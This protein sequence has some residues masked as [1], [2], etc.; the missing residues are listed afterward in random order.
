MIRTR[1]ARLSLLLAVL[2]GVSAWFPFPVPE[3]WSGALLED[4]RLGEEP[5]EVRTE[6]LTLRWGTGSL[7]V[8]GLTARTPQRLLL[9][10]ERA[11]LRLDLRP[12]SPHFLRPRA[13]D[14]AGIEL[15]LLPDDLARLRPA[16]SDATFE[17]PPVELR[18]RDVAARMPFPDGR[19]LE[20]ALPAAEGLLSPSGSRIRGRAVTAYGLSAEFW[21]RAGEGFRDWVVDLRGSAEALE[22]RGHLPWPARAG[23]CE[24]ALRVDADDVL[25]RLDFRELTLQVPE[26]AVELRAPRLLLEGSLRRGMRA[27]V[28]F[29]AGPVTLSGEAWLRQPGDAPLEL[30]LEAASPQPVVIGPELIAYLRTV[31]A[32]TA[33]AF[34]ALELRGAVPLRVAL[35]W[36]AGEAPRAAAHSAF[37]DF[38]CTYR[39]FLEDDGDRPSFPY[40]ATGMRGDIAA[41][42]P[43]LLIQADGRVGEGT[44]GGWCTVGIGRGPAEVLLDLQGSALPVDARVTSAA[45]G[46]PALSAVWR[47]L[48]GP[49]S[50]SADFELFV[51]SPSGSTDA[52]LRIDA[53]ATGTRVRPGFLPIEAEAEEV[54]LSWMPGLAEFDG[55]VRT[56]GGR[57][58]LDGR[59]ESAA[60][61]ELPAAR[62]RAHSLSPLTPSAPE[63]RVLESFL[64][65]PRGF[66][67]FELAG[68]AGLSGSFL[69][70]G[71]GELQALLRW[72]GADAEL[73]WLP[74][75][76]TWSRL[77]GTVTV[78]RAGEATSV[79]APLL[80]C[81]CSGGALEAS[82]E[83]AVGLP[84]AAASRALVQVRGLR[85][86]E[87]SER[88]AR[89]IVGLSE[90]SRVDWSG[91]V[92]LAVE[93]DPLAPERNRGWVELRPLV[94]QEAGAEAA[95]GVSLSGRLQL[96]DDRIVDGRLVSATPAG[97]FRLRRFSLEREDGATRLQAR[98]DSEGVELGESFAA[99]LSPEAWQAFQRIGLGGR[100][101]ADD[102]QLRLLVTDGEPEFSLT[103]GLLLDG[104]RVFGPPRMEAG[105][106]RLDVESFR[107]AGAQDYAGRLRLQD[108]AVVVSGVSLTEAAGTVELD[109]T[110]VTLRGF[111]AALLGGAVRTDEG[112]ERGHLR[113]GL[114]KEAPIDY[115]LFLD[116]V[117]LRQLREELGLG[118]DLAGSVRGRLEFRS[119]S[120]S[121]LDYAGAGWLEVEQGALGAVPVL[122]RMWRVANLA[123]PIFERG[124]VEFRAD[125]GSSRGRLR[126][127]RFELHHPLLEVRGKGWVG[128]DSTLNLKA[129]V[130]TLSFLTRLPLVRDVVDLFL[131][132][133]VYG[134]LDRP[135]IRQRALGKMAD[136]LPDR[137]PFPLWTPTFERA[138]WRLSPALPATLDPP[139]EN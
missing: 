114:S 46:T 51:R 133:D 34:D 63:R 23:A 48:G 101:A 131:E 135:R 124:R 83:L 97:D 85:V 44:V 105:S 8:R 21:F 128:L 18:L 1:R 4:L 22:D 19:V 59:F 78:V 37:E 40:P 30:R 82:G 116:G 90:D 109:G 69:R 45:S 123:P 54:R 99:L 75:G 42:G 81:S 102:L 117:R 93:L 103:G 88:L 13:A 17:P 9:G 31:E 29:G 87:E 49:S 111:S 50:G 16:G 61:E 119:D 118:G 130:R 41:A 67:G 2:V 129:T 91:E 24:A 3:A 11:D 137:L 96:R 7:I 65:L 20:L 112:E 15:G 104:V 39:G 73:R 84:A 127:D 139:P 12:W 66:A 110:D 106:G 122:S 79:H 92:D 60:G 5:V 77:R 36:R 113:L 25:A 74:L 6:Q 86:E 53:T 26:P 52:G 27:E 120:P 62:V 95:S 64:Q 134:P 28:E 43:R 38:A 138:D 58:A 14:L 56:L 125:P 55:V 68:S 32:T 35:D 100:V 89:R 107:W 76:T 80:Q 10:A 71:A 121:P 126:V 72:D 136:P 132:Q 115:L 108:G 57:V 98:V 94:A 70:T 33:E 47:E